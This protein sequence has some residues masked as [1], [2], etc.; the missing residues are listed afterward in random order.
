MMG[1]WTSSEPIW[2][3]CDIHTLKS[4]RNWE[5]LVE[6]SSLVVKSVVK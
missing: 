4:L 3:V 5:S 1:L 6:T 2:N